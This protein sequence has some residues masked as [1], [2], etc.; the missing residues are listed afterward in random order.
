MA[1]RAAPWLDGSAITPDNAKRLAASG[2]LGAAFDAE[3]TPSN[4][5][6]APVSADTE[7][8]GMVAAAATDSVGDASL[9]P[10]NTAAA[11]ASAQS[12]VVASGACQRA[13]E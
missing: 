12:P 9:R 1:I 7:G 5:A 4:R 2:V 13:A 11:A 8:R 10:Q 3:T 6:S